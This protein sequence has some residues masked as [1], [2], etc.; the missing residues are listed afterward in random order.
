MIRYFFIF[1]LL[2]ELL[3]SYDLKKLSDNEEFKSLFH[4][5]KEKS[6]ITDINFF[7]SK[8]KFTP[9]NEIKMLIEKIDDKNICK[10]P[11]RYNFLKKHTNLNISFKHCKKLNKFMDTNMGD[12]VSMIFASNYLGSPTSYFGHTFLKINKRNNPMFSQTISYTAQINS[13]DD[14]F[15][16]IAKGLSGGYKG[17]YLIN[18][19]FKL[20]ETYNKTEQRNLIEYLLDLNKEEI[21]LMLLHTY[22]LK[23]IDLKYDFFKE[24]CA[25]QL[26]W[27]LKNARVD[28]NL[29]NKYD[30][31]IIP[32]ET[33]D[34]LKNENLI[35]SSSLRASKINL[36]YNEYSKL[37]G[38]QKKK[39]TKL[40]QSQNKIEVLNNSI[41]TEKEKDTMKYLLNEYYY[42]LFK[43][44]RYYKKDYLDV[45]NLIYKPREKLTN[46]EDFEPKK[47]QKIKIS[48]IKTQKD[49][50]RSINYRPALFDKYE[51]Y[52]KLSQKTL[53]VGNIS[54]DLI[55]DDIKINKF[56]YLNLESYNKDFPFYIPKTWKLTIESNKELENK[57]Q[58][59]F[60]G[61][62]GK[63]YGGENSLFY[64]MLGTSIFPS[65]EEITLDTLSGLSYYYKDFIISLDIMKSIEYIKYRPK[66]KEKLSIR[67]Q[68]D[69]N[70]DIFYTFDK[71]STY[72]T[73]SLGL[74]F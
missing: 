20:I 3:H 11:A 22:E 65:S 28:L 12:T 7:I 69:K 55:S 40:I 72:H 44:Y 63:S 46:I 54:F 2:F 14:F 51:S 32:F 24:N 74:F 27:L 56:T 47:A 45:K 29:L 31:I 23:T 41:F 61:S 67:K 21:Y 59:M 5:N 60:H 48:Y 13:N 70:I 8:E 71:V 30:H 53:E 42:V 37:S 10:Y 19:Y 17:K 38:D 33:I 18:P 25:Y 4:I 1:I 35:R 43:Q 34:L 62:Y 9:Y 49:N 52:D 64:I 36:I 26:L 50:Y 15:G 57:F 68:I 66:S 6:E 39:F 73:F 16:I 58:L